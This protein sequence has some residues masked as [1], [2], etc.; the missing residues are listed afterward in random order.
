MYPHERSLVKR[1]ANQPFAL[2][3]INSDPKEKVIAAL[4]RENISWRSFWDGGSTGGPIARDWNVRGWPTIYVVDDRGVIRYKNVRGEKM[5]EAVDELL[6]SAVVTLVKNIKSDDPTLRGLAAF[7]IGKYNAPD[8]VALIR[9][10][11]KDKD[12]SVKQR[13]ATGLALLGES[14]KP[15]LELIRK[16]VADEESEVRVASIDVLGKANDKK[17]VAL[18]SKALE[19][20]IVDVRRT[21]IATLGKLGDPSSVPALSKAVDDEDRETAKAAAYAL[22]EMKAPQSIKALKELADNDQHPARVWIAIAMHRA[23]QK[24][25]EGRFETLLKDEDAQVRQLA[26][27][28]LADL[29]DIDATDLLILALE[30]EAQPVCKVASGLL[31][32]NDSPRAKKALEKYLTKRIK[33]IVE[34]LSDTNRTKQ[35]QAQAELGQLGPE[36]APHLLDAMEGEMTP[37]AAMYVGRAIGATGNTDALEPALDKLKDADLDPQ[38]RSSYEYVLRGMMKDARKQIDELA[39]HPDSAVRISGIRLLMGQTDDEAIKL[40]KDAISDEDNMVRVTAAYGLSIRKDK[41]ALAE[42]QKLAKT[43]ESE[44]LPMILYG[45]GN[46]PSKEATDTI[47]QVIADNTQSQVRSM[48]IQALQRQGTADAV[49]VL[50]EFLDDEDASIQR[51]AR[52]ALTRMRT[53]EAKKILEEHQKKE[54]AE[55]KKDK[56]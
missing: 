17:S 18:V 36:A 10:V 23:G 16:A 14:P 24:G 11:L 5:D 41:D 8:A 49:N 31:A 33:F 46:Y 44:Q 29:A 19:D 21:A 52:S 25:T 4:D 47:A 35:R 32:E 50:G 37:L 15:L 42:L 51:L 48:A 43:V 6:K 26:V 30:D 9:P 53:P 3:G 34:G 45:L 39:G 13:A 27:S 40:L 54:K 22:A 7:R 1:L 28:S 12:D 20:E 38:K 56:G 2:I 55:D